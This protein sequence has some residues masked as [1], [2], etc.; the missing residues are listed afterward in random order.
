[1]PPWPSLACNGPMLWMTGLSLLIAIGGVGSALV[2]RFREPLPAI[3]SVAKP[4]ASLD[5][6]SGRELLPDD[7]VSPISF[8][9]P[10]MQPNELFEWLRNSSLQLSPTSATEDRQRAEQWVQ[11][12]GQL[13]RA[14]RYEEAV[15]AFGS[16][17]QYDSQNALYYYLLAMSQYEAKQREDAR[18]SLN[19]ALALERTSPIP[20]WG[21]LVSR[22]QGPAR[23]WVEHLRSKAQAANEQ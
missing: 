6:T 11:H 7:D 3:R 22:Y 2:L 8:E 1:M 18:R 12:G 15:A 14:G 19:A 23:L 5:A 13:Y 9:E 20:S 21:Q 17:I 10:G 16:A 4:S